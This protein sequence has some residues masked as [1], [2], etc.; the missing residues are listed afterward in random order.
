MLLKLRYFSHS[1]FELNNTKT[2]LIDP[3]FSGNKFAPKYEGTP[4]LILITHE[5]FDHSD[6]ANFDCLVL[7]PSTCKFKR[8]VTMNIG[9]TFDFSGISIK[10]VKASLHH[11]SKYSSGY[12]INY[13]GKNVYHAGD[14]YL[15]AINKITQVDIFMVPIGGT[16]T[17][18]ID[19]A[20]K[21][22]K[23]IEPGLTIPMHYNTFPEIKAEP[24]E[25]QIKTEKLGFKVKIMNFG[26]EIGI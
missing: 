16:Y 23:I 17:M 18:N 3:Y 15:D 11:D 24:K 1:C 22:V 20:V 26:E 9:D 7:A 14:T 25:F 10:A 5:H 12:L 13:K 8:M 2:V 4:D 19:E 21:A 6:A